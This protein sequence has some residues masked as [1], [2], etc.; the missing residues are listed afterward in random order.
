MGYGNSP[1]PGG[2]IST[3]GADLSE[4]YQLT[5]G[6]SPSPCIYADAKVSPANSPA[7]LIDSLLWANAKVTPANNAAAQINSLFLIRTVPLSLFPV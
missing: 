4:L 5:G 7:A 1:A 2:L 3:Y 6:C